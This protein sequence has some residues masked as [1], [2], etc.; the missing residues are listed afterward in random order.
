MCAEGL[1]GGGL[2]RRTCMHRP[3]WQVSIANKAQAM[4]A[5]EKAL[6]MDILY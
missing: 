1:K 5:D 3:W 2:L 4:V 6:G